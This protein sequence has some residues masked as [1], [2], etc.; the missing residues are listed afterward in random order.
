MRF[1]DDPSDGREWNAE[2][3]TNFSTTYVLRMVTTFLLTPHLLSNG[4]FRIELWYSVKFQPL[5][6]T[7]KSPPAA[8]PTSNFP[9]LH[10]SDCPTLT[11]QY[12][13]CTLPHIGIWFRFYVLT[14]RHFSFSTYSISPRQLPLLLF[15]SA[16]SFHSWNILKRSHLF[17]CIMD[18]I[19][20][21]LPILFPDILH[22]AILS[23]SMFFVFLCT[24]AICRRPTVHAQPEDSPS[25]H[26][27]SGCNNTTV[28]HS[29]RRRSRARRQNNLTVI[30]DRRRSNR[31]WG[32]LNTTPTSF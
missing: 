24:A 9:S 19:L 12:P 32:F 25:S 1:T 13:E 15:V 20:L 14:N 3:F 8:A 23:T 5:Y 7:I 6:D 17:T 4:T 18:P 31:S 28:L 11:T 22:F 21:L 10:H 30:C 27:N 26:V 2:I 16:V 29:G